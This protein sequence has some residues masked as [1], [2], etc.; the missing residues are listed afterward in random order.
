MEDLCA[1]YK[2]QVL[3]QL[4]S[5]RELNDDEIVEIIDSVFTKGSNVTIRANKKNEY[6]KNGLREEAVNH[7]WNPRCSPVLI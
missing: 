7:R 4:D 6:R 5:S 2:E 1:F 3:S